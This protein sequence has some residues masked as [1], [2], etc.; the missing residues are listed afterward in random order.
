MMDAALRALVAAHCQ[1]EIDAAYGAYDR[2][3]IDE[4]D[5]WGSL[6]SFH[7]ANLL[8]RRAPGTEGSPASGGPIPG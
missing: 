2:H 4:P 1:A 3:P 8:H 5:A 7:E 6:A